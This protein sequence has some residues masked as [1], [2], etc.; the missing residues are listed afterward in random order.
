L[1]A[2]AKLGQELFYGKAACVKCHGDSALGDGQ[3]TDYDDWNKTVH[4]MIED[5]AKSRASI[6]ANKDMSSEERSKELAKLADLS[7][8]LAHDALPPRTIQP[9]NL[10]Q[11]YYRFGRRPLDLFRRITTGINGVPM[12]GVGPASPGAAGLA[13]D[14][15]WQ[16]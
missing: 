7:S 13:A 15:I 11:G 4:D 10:R 1:A 3:A 6:A 16:L 5:V 2:S 9:R 12:P 8:V 14:D